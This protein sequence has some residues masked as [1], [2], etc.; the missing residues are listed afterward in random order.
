MKQHA[1]G[2]RVSL[3]RNNELYIVVAFEPSLTKC[4]TLES[5]GKTIYAPASEV[6]AKSLTID[7]VL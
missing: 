5:C 2:S 3:L 7:E 4:Y 1:I 6:V